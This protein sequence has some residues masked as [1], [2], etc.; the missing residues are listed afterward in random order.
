MDLTKVTRHR[1]L[2]AKNEPQ[3]SIHAALVRAK[4]NGVGRLI[5]NF[6]KIDVVRFTSG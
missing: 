6:G 3:V 2:V 4:Q 5:H 1:A